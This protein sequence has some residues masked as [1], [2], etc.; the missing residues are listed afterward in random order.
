LGTAIAIDASLHPRCTLRRNARRNGRKARL[1]AAT[2]LPWYC[3][4][5]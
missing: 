2:W 1:P 3:P 5:H 4:L